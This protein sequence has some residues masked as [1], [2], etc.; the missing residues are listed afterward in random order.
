MKNSKKRLRIRKSRKG[1]IDYLA[2]QDLGWRKF[3]RYAKQRWSLKAWKEALERDPGGIDRLKALELEWAESE[4][5][6]DFRRRLAET[7]EAPFTIRQREL[8]KK[9]SEMG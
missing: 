8:A 1:R 9:R 4:A 3:L 6:R 7:G 5:R 2:Q